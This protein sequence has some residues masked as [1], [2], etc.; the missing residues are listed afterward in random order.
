M[1]T[2]GRSGLPHLYYPFGNSTLLISLYFFFHYFMFLAAFFFLNL[3][4]VS[5]AYNDNVL[6][7]SLVQAKFILGDTRGVL[8]WG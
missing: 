8:H 4:R 6:W 2:G 3:L 5:N 7:L 1:L